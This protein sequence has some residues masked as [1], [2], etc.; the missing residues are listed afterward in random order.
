M[1]MRLSH[2]LDGEA[3]SHLLFLSTPVRAAYLLC[4]APH[5]ARFSCARLDLPMMPLFLVCACMMSRARV[6]CVNRLLCP[7]ATF[8]SLPLTLSFP[9]SLFSYHC[10]SFSRMFYCARLSPLAFAPSRA[11]RLVMCPRSP[12]PL[13][14][15]CLRSLATMLLS[16]CCDAVLRPLVVMCRPFVPLSL[17]T[18]ATCTA[19]CAVR[20]VSV[21]PGSTCPFLHVHVSACMRYCWCC[22]PLRALLSLLV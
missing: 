11:V 20:T 16:S 15:V 5:C 18:V 14:A 6:T 4:Y 9:P 19:V 1:A 13:C 21:L 12:I 7:C 22:R 8:A 3:S 2:R 10:T 17:Y